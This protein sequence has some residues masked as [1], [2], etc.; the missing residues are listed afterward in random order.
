MVVPL[1]F[2]TSVVSHAFGAAPTNAVPA[3]LDGWQK[4]GSRD[5]PVKVFVPDMPNLDFSN[6]TAGWDLPQGY[7]FDPHGGRRGGRCLMYTRPEGGRY[8]FAGICFPV[9]KLMPGVTYGFGCW[10]KTEGVHGGN[11]G[12][13]LIEFGGPYGYLGGVTPME[14][15][16]AASG[17]SDWKWVEGRFTVPPTADGFVLRP[18]LTQDAAGK[19]WFDGIKIYPSTPAFVWEAWRIRPMAGLRSDDGKIV[20]RSEMKG[21]PLPPPREVDPARLLCAIDVKQKGRTIVRNVAPVVEKWVETDLGK[22]AAGDYAMELSL[23]DPEHKMILAEASEPLRVEPA[24]AKTPPPPGAC[25]VDDRGRCIVDGKPFMPVGVYCYRLDR[26]NIRRLAD[27][28]FN[29][30]APYSLLTCDMD[31]G[32]DPNKPGAA[33][34]SSNAETVRATLDECHRNGLKVSVPFTGAYWAGGENDTERFGVSGYKAVIAKT[35]DLFKRHPAVLTWYIADEPSAGP[36]QVHTG[37][38]KVETVDFGP[39]L[40]DI[41]QG[42]KAADPWHPLWSVFIGCGVLTHDHRPLIGTSDIVSIDVYPI[43]AKNQ[44]EM[45][46]I[47]LYCDRIESQFGGRRGMPFWAVPQLQ[48]LGS[49]DYSVRSREEF[50][51]RHREPTGDEMLGMALMF[52]IHGSKGFIFY[53]YHDLFSQYAAPDF[54]RRWP[55]TCRMAKE[56]NSLAPFIMSDADGPP[57]EA[58]F[59]QGIGSAK[60]FADERGKTCVLISAGVYGGP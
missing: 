55:E 9:A 50:V 18:M 43:D 11:G 56:L 20:I 25:V 45:N 58:A 46:A 4:V 8:T 51:A 35:V 3:S 7:S 39:F 14:E 34:N 57:V 59:C 37:P 38:N 19:I 6:G 24:V 53:S 15:G 47:P 60:G 54:S 41:C 36:R 42:V 31:C 22:L 23:L 40:K 5:T 44:F 12:G 27:A 10:I 16:K 32:V 21:L 49:Y 30:V 13:L 1:L 28:G 48:N 52:A 2:M 33:V 29:C 17:T 26:K